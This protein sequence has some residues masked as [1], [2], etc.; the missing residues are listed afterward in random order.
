M[1]NTNEGRI[2]R[3]RSNASASA[4]IK[5]HGEPLCDRIAHRVDGVH[6]VPLCVKG[7]ACVRPRAYT[8]GDALSSEE[9]L[10]PDRKK[11]EGRFRIPS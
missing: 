4:S 7:P 8:N 2:A 10:M 1:L 6:R 5:R 11:L 3:R 9:V